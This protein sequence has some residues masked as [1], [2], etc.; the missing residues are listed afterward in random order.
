MCK[1]LIYLALA[2]DH[3]KY[4]NPDS[5]SRIL[6][7]QAFIVIEFIHIIRRAAITKLEKLCKAKRFLNC[8]VDYIVEKVIVALN[9]VTHPANKIQNAMDWDGTPKNPPETTINFFSGVLGFCA[10]DSKPDGD[11]IPY[12]PD[13][14]LGRKIGFYVKLAA[15]E[16]KKLMKWFK[17]GKKRS[18]LTTNRQYDV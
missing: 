1:S 2:V 11:D 3:Q 15:N 9:T 8:E 7:K 12:L 10:K 13:E 18:P 6:V 5:A 4:P 17:M 16:I 14:R